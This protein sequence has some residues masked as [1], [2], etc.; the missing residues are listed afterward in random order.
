MQ[1]F[2][3]GSSFLEEL[4]NISRSTSISTFFAII[5]VSS[6]GTSSFSSF[7][8]TLFDISITV[9]ISTSDDINDFLKILNKLIY[10]RRPRRFRFKRRKYVLKS[11]HDAIIKFGI[12]II[13]L[14]KRPRR[15]S[16]PGPPDQKS[17]ALSWLGY[18]ATYINISRYILKD[19]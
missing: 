12:I 14:L 5:S 13:K 8:F 1:G 3:L 11:F 6:P 15:D 2:F 7:S 16:N 10:L 18:G 17:D 19:F 9:L 4:P